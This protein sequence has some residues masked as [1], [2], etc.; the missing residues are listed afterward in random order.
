[1]FIEANKVFNKPPNRK[2][3]VSRKTHVTANH[4]YHLIIL[5]NKKNRDAISLEQSCTKNLSTDKSLALDSL[6]WV[7]VIWRISQTF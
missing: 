4:A 1:M 7:H 5:L 3:N 6:N 2:F